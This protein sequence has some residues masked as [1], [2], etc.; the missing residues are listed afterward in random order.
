MTP[1]QHKTATAQLKELRKELIEIADSKA[2][3][4]LSFL[5]IRNF[6]NNEKYTATILAQL[7]INSDI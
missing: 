5:K 7:I 1:E 3:E 2:V 4:T 6:I